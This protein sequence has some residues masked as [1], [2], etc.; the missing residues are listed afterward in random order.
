[1]EEMWREKLKRLKQAK[2]VHQKQ[3]GIKTS[4]VIRVHAASPQP[5]VYIVFHAASLARIMV[6]H[7]RIF[8]FVM[9]NNDLA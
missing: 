2:P 9:F 5:P 4:V 6:Y 1:M 8:K 7:G 3:A